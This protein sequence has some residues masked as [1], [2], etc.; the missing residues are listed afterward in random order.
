MN[1]EVPRIAVVG[2]SARF[3]VGHGREAL[4]AAM[5]DAVSP[6]RPLPSDRFDPSVFAQDWPEGSPVRAEGALI[7]DTALD[8]RALRLPPMAAE[9]MHRMERVALATMAEALADAGI[10]TDRGPEPRGRI[11]LAA[12][13][14]A[15][16]PATDH[17]PR[18][19]RFEL[20]APV[21]D[22]V[23]E[24]LPEA[25][26]TIEEYVEQLFN[27]AAPPV[28][29]DSM[30]TS[31]SV[32][33]GRIANLFDFRGGHF[34]VDAAASSSF[35]ALQEAVEV[36]RAGEADLVLVCAISPL[37]TASRVLAHAHR[38]ELGDRPPRPYAADAGGTTLGEGCVAVVLQREHDVRGKVFG[39]VEGVGSSVAFSGGLA[40][41]VERASRRALADA[42]AAPE[43]IAG[44]VTRAAG[45]RDVDAAEA[46]G[47][48]AAYGSA[49]IRLRSVV[50]QTGFLG[51][52][53]GL[54]ALLA[55]LHAL[56]SAEPSLFTAGGPGAWSPDT[57]LGVSD[58]GHSA[59]A[60]HAVI[61]GA[62]SHVPT[63]RS[64]RVAP[65]SETIPLAIVGRGV[66]APGASDAPSFFRNVV[67]GAETFDD[68]PESRWDVARLLG[69]SRE[70]GSILTSR[71]AG[72]IDRRTLVRAERTDAG[73]A[74]AE[75]D[76]SVAMCVV[77]GDEA[78]R[79]SGA[80]LDGLDPERIAVLVGQ[81]P[82]RE[83]EV[84]AEK[85]V[86]FAGHLRLVVE[87]M[88][89]AE[90]PP[91]RIE[92]VTTLARR[93]FD[94]T[95]RRFDRHTLDAFSGL[96]AATALAERHGF[97]GGLLCVDA[98]CASSLVA[99]D[100][101]RRKLQTHEL[102]AV[103]VGGIVANLLP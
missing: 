70:L 21:S 102:D 22:A 94:L 92:Q 8:F 59:M 14:L 54:A 71:L 97:R 87:A 52:A 58:A 84:E 7:E 46:V 86:L 90:I 50:P 1:R 67:E 75:Q 79:S 99:L 9:K 33:A 51:P 29:P 25:H 38:G 74:R 28:E 10:R 89:E 35:A 82:L 103:V 26:E 64:D 85:R 66:L 41:A 100:V 77:A 68:L 78:V 69:A 34:A 49:D 18:I 61:S 40:A 17:G 2:S 65:S 13:G 95:T 101:A 43:D 19:R 83:L 76:P 48:E 91:D 93:S 32:L 81:L 57:R 62:G 60:F 56:A 23:A 15:P 11:V 4:A 31:A 44:C 96:D 12:T 63:R 36:L 27:L 73:G 88:R 20:A 37:V 47:L 39:F 24:I 16:D 98:A 30:A 80:R 6:F 45:W 3:A 55:A 53:G 72:T 5:R 42:G